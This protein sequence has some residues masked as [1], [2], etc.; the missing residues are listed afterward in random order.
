VSG[1]LKDPKGGLT[2]EGRRKYKRETGANLK[3]A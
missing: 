2:A 3:P 1:P